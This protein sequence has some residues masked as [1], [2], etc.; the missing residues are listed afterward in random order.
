MKIQQETLKERNT[1][2]GADAKSHCG[3]WL[4]T[5]CQ[6][7]QAQKLNKLDFKECHLGYPKRKFE[8]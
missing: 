3:K 8:I 2:K 6:M 4:K 7:L 5:Y 1:E